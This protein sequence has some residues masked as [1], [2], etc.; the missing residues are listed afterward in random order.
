MEP[1]LV[2]TLAGSDHFPFEQHAGSAERMESN[3]ENQPGSI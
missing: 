3:G 2:Q 1:G